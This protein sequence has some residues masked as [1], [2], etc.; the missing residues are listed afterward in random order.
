MISLAVTT[1]VR[2]QWFSV[3]TSM[4][5]MKR[6]IWP[7]PRNR[8]ARSAIWWS[9]APR[10]TTQL[11]LIGESPGRLRCGDPLEH[12]RG[13][14]VAAAHAPEHLFV[15]A[16]EA[17]RDPAQPGARERLGLLREQI[18]VGRE[19]EIEQAGDRGE[20]LDQARQ[21]VAQQRLAARDADLL[22][23]ERNEQARQPLDLLEREQLGP[24]HE[25]VVLAV[26]LGG[27]AVGAAEVAAVG[28]RDAQI[29]QAASQ[30]IAHGIT[31]GIARASPGSQC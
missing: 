7:V 5:S 27:H 22:D 15:V 4:N 29:V 2:S 1:W 23:A 28:D 6:T 21:L 16:V 24:R 18:A 30:S 10:C 20:S 25:A 13:A 14:E 19:R 12:A 9:F 31:R 17:H 8:R 3:P 26:D 11:I